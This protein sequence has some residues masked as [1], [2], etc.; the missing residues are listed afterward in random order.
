MKI[1]FNSNVKVSDLKDLKS[2]NGK[3]GFADLDEKCQNTIVAFLNGKYDGVWETFMRM[4]PHKLNPKSFF[5]KKYHM[6]LGMMYDV[7]FFKTGAKKQY[8]TTRD[9]NV[10]LRGDRIHLPFYVACYREGLSFRK[11]D[12]I[13]IGT[14][15]E[16]RTY[17]GITPQWLASE[18]G[19]E[20][21]RYITSYLKIVDRNVNI[22]PSYRLEFV[23]AVRASKRY[24]KK[25]S[26]SKQK[27]YVND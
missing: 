14:D 25:K 26:Y 16:G 4:A 6:V 20:D 11:E 27:S 12:N 19:I 3:F 21:W 2:E 13:Y 23:D 17:K 5:Y 9:I 1:Q 22:V 24:S 10:F 7:D 8:G 15:S 18:M